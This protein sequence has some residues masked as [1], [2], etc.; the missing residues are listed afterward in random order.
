MVNVLLLGTVRPFGNKGD[1]AIYIT[2][3]NLIRKYLPN[4]KV[5]LA[6]F[7]HQKVLKQ[8]D[9]DNAICHPMGYPFGLIMDRIP[10]GSILR[11]VIKCVSYRTPSYVSALS[12]KLFPS[13][14][15]EIYSDADLCVV[16]PFPF[17]KEGFPV[18]VSACNIVRYYD[19]RKPVLIFPISISTSVLKGHRKNIVKRSLS[20][21]NIVFTRGEYTT[22]ILK[23]SLNLENILTAFDPAVL[24][25]KIE[26]V[27]KPSG[28]VAITP[29]GLIKHP[30]ILAKL[31]ETLIEKLGIECWIVP[32]SVGELKE[33]FLGLIK[34][35]HMC[36]II[37]TGKMSPFEVKG[38]LSH[39]DVLITARVHAAIFALSENI[40]TVAILR[41]DD[42]K[43]YDV[44]EAFGLDYFIFDMK[45]DPKNTLNKIVQS[46]SEILDRKTQF[47]NIIRGKKQ[48]VIKKA[49]IPG[50]LLRRI[51]TC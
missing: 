34:N 13:Q 21:A 44:L 19:P 15:R 3:V 1:E 41:E 17:E 35:T 45:F 27:F 9:V 30:K 6:S 40:P 12:L 29:A 28:G 16:L 24:L 26:P 43:F 5:V 51:L 32:T 31:V 7:E 11:R 39:V 47:V 22:K 18:Y 37:D 36:S 2:T 23:K 25:P 50:L 33:N 4:S 48:H 14:Y 49:E 20:K 38:F 42:V 10:S 46:V 8:Y